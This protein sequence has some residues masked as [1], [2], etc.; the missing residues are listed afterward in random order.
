MGSSLHRSIQVAASGRIP[1][2]LQLKNIALSIYLS[3]IFFIRSS[4]DGYLG[5]FHILAV[6]NNAALITGGTGMK[7]SVFR[8]YQCH[9]SGCI[10]CIY[11]TMVL[12][13]VPIGETG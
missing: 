6:V 10:H 4:A 9:Y 8:L 2:F 3:H 12:Q 1:F 7:Y 11:C 13:D 5:C